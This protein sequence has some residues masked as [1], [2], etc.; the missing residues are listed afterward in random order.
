VLILRYLAKGE[1]HDKLK[2]NEILREHGVA[3]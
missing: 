2:L 3:S 1:E